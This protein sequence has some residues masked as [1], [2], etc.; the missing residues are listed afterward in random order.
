[1]VLQGVASWITAAIHLSTASKGLAGCV[2][3]A[4]APTLTVPAGFAQTKGVTSDSVCH[5]LQSLL[6]ANLSSAGII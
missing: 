6:P 1:M 2:C 3:T 5:R 4:R